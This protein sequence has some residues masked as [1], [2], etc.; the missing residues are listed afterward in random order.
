MRRWILAREHWRFDTEDLLRRWDRT[1]PIVSIAAWQADHGIPDRVFVK[2]P[3]QRKSIALDLRSV[4]QG[5]LLRSLAATSDE[6][7]VTEMA[8]QPDRCWLADRAGAGYVSELR[9]TVLRRDNK[10]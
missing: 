6:I 3:A 1:S 9:F 4:L 10:D 2:V 8:P 7:R 5:D